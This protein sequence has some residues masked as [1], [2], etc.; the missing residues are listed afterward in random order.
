MTSWL[1]ASSRLRRWSLVRSTR[2]VLLLRT[3]GACVVMLIL[4]SAALVAWDLRRTTVETYQRSLTALGAAVAG[5]TARYIQVVDLVTDDVRRVALQNAP[6][7]TAQ[8]RALVATA[9]MH[10]WLDA[11]LRDAPQVAAVFLVD[12]TG[13]MINSSRPG[14]APSLDVSDRDYFRAVQDATKGGAYISR[15]LTSRVTGGQTLYYSKRL[16]GPD[17]AFLGAVVAAIDVNYLHG[18]YRSVS[19]TPGQ[20]ITLLRRDGL[21]LARYPAVS[22]LPDHR[23]PPLSQWYALTAA[24]GGVYSVP[25][26]PDPAL[27]LFVAVHPLP[28]YGLVVD[29]NMTRVAVLANWRHDTLLIGVGAIVAAVAFAA[30]MLVIETMVRRQSVQNRRLR[31]AAEVLRLREHELSEKSHLLETTLEHMDQGLMMIA[32]D[33]TIPICNRRARE[34]LDLPEKLMARHPRF[35]EVLAYQW[36]QREFAGSDEEFQDFVRRALLLGG[37]RL[38]ERRRPNGR[39]LE[40]RTTSLPEGEAVRT[41]TDVTERH[42]AA[43]RLAHAK[44]AAEAARA[45]SEQASRAK[46]EFLAT[47]SHELRTPLNAIIGFSELIRDHPFGSISP[48]YVEYANDI[49]SSGRHLLSLV[50]DLLDMAKIEAGHY[51]LVEQDLDLNA[52]AAGCVRMVQGQADAGQVRIEMGGNLPGYT[53][54]ADARALRQILVNLLSNAVKFTPAGGTVNVDAQDTPDRGLALVVT[55]SGIGMSAAA[56]SAVGQPFHQVDSSIRRHFGGSGLGL[57]ICRRLTELHGASLTLQSA[58]GEGTTVRVV[59]GPERVAA[60]A[61]QVGD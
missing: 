23:L 5:Q 16:S 13:M 58:P 32:A 33:R 25:G 35:E 41:Y 36:N 38:Y 44:E 47:M 6:R 60:R 39:V 52:L 31:R 45:L 12:A 53:L 29:V 11:R 59:F 26:D 42:A 40:V 48:R 1:Q 46:S 14:P 50:N 2:A 8:F 49:N 51:A 20:S 17:G 19:L 37:P 27:S 10:Q 18:F 7:N 28:E 34:L 15:P 61:M 54:F 21:V 24:G 30:L 22:L 56:L 4:S 57:A 3:L 55:D 43:E 9:E